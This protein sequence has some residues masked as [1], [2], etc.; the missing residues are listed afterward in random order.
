MDLQ[1]YFVTITLKPSSK[2]TSWMQSGKG[3]A[4]GKSKVEQKKLDKAFINDEPE[5]ISEEEKDGADDALQKRRGLRRRMLDDSDEV[6]D[7]YRHCTNL[8]LAC[9]CV[10]QSL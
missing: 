8:W 5:E 2:T 4:D 3:K 1:V 7:L 10:S 6:N 9:C